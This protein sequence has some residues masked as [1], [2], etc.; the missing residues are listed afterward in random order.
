[1][2]KFFVVIIALL[3][4]IPSF[5][6]RQFIHFSGAL[7]Q[8]SPNDAAGYAISGNYQARFLGIFRPGLG[9]EAS[10][11]IGDTLGLMSHQSALD[12]NLTWGAEI[13][14]IGIR[15]AGGV[16]LFGRFWQKSFAADNTGDKLYSINGINYTLNSGSYINY[17]YLTWGYLFY[18]SAGLDIT[19]HLGAY[20]FYQGKKDMT[21]DWINSFGVGISFMLN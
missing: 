13:K 2:R 1:M 12:G 11:L 14:L 16:G 8:V 15:F 4:L 3:L 6:Q 5:G 7:A 17:Q 21:Q 18:V 10:S 19:S 9:I 20:L